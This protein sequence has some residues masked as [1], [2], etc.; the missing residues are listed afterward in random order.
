MSK[1]ELKPEYMAKKFNSQKEFDCWL[2]NAT[3]K[4]LILASFGQDMQRFG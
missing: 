4:E 2:S 1:I 3:F